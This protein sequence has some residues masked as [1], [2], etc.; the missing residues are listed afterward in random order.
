MVQMQ[1]REDIDLS[2]Q[3][4]IERI[5]DRLRLFSEDSS[6]NSSSDSD[7]SEKDTAQQPFDSS[8][9]EEL[10]QDDNFAFDDSFLDEQPNDVKMDQYSEYNSNPASVNRILESYNAQQS[11]EY[12]N[13]YQSNPFSSG[14]EDWVGDIASDSTAENSNIEDDFLEDFNSESRV[15]NSNTTDETS[16][17]KQESSMSLNMTLEDFITNMIAKNAFD[18]MFRQQVSDKIDAWFEDVCMP[19]VQDYM[20]QTINQWCEQNAQHLISQWCSQS[21]N[22]VQS[23]VKVNPF[24]TV[25]NK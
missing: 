15:E 10:N 5:K 19:A 25:S 3:N 17:S 13:I 22:Q 1:S 6:T 21:S 8:S 12:Q 14:D 16:H 23:K 2:T 7:F 20:S 24:H 11:R 4:I 18:P 9:F